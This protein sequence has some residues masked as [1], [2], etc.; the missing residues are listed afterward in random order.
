VN[1]ARS[2]SYVDPF[3]GVDGEGNCLCGPYL[4]HSIVRLGPDTLQPHLSHGYHSDRPIIRFS[5]TH[6]SGT[7]G[8]G[9][10][11]NIGVTPFTGALRTA[12]QPYEKEEESA[13]PG[14]YCVTL[15][16]SN[17]KAELTVTPRV[18]VH[19][20][21]F[22]DVSNANI[23]LDV[24]S[25]IEVGGDIPGNST[26]LSIGG[27][28]E[29]IS[30][31]EVV[32]R[33]DF[34]GGWGHDFPYSVYFYAKL[35]QPIL[36]YQTRN[37]S[38]ELHS[39]SIDGPNCKV[40][41]AFGNQK[42]IGLRVG[43]SYV[44]VANARDSVRKEAR[45]KSFAALR[46]EAADIWEHALQRIR[47]EGGTEQQKT[48]FYTLFTRLIC[49]PSDLGID[50]ENPLWKSGVR[51]F[52]DF[53][54]LW[55]S[56]RNANSL[57]SLF[58]PEL[59]V[60]MLNC[61]LD[62][63][64]HVGW[65]PDAWIMGH[66]AMIQGGS[67][68]DVLLCEAALKGLKGI[69]YHKALRQMRKNNEVESPNTWLYGRHLSDYHSLGYLS[70]NVKKNCVSRHME[71]AYQDWCI[72]RLAE[73]LNDL[74]TAETYYESSRKIWNL[75]RDDIQF[76]AP[77]DPDGKWVE[78]F[79]PASCL[80]DSWND[81]YFYEGTSWQWS[82][83]V[84]HDFSGLIQRH[85]GEEGFI[86]H[87][88]RFFDEGH[89]YSK[90]TM[91]HVPYLYTYAGRPD[92]TAERVRECLDKYFKVAR[93]GLRDNEDMGCQS[94][95]YMCSGIGLYPIMGQDLYLISTPIFKKTEI[96]LGRSGKKLIIEAPAADEGHLYIT[97]ATLNGKPLNRA[98]VKHHE[99]AD[100]A[101]IRLE[102]SQ[103]PG[104]WGMT[105]IPP[106]PLQALN[107]VNSK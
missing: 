104:N 94:A 29:V 60:D 101:V 14:Y 59:E 25:V 17:I 65:L 6:V 31:T 12:L 66:S 51:H 103:K 49:M 61:L 107:S 38:D 18:G 91:L 39:S 64:D 19:R 78:P 86:R 58:D 32:G 15:M 9:R 35:D 50:D 106:S 95:F 84:H 69:D 42:E 1:N 45:A 55:D 11:G 83:S 34:R 62:I 63:A 76:F 57:I 71:Y 53:Y 22:P 16:P 30:D 68:A 40:A 75:W 8:G 33:G 77:K 73:H 20:Y 105:E 36:T 99:I 27:F 85:G 97:S 81:P 79:E 26:G 21:T 46:E 13:A 82:F 41:L 10:Y 89:H 88:D 43:I 52:T 87:L 2:V 48:L 28:L 44:S 102:V 24:G 72:G 67:S 7:G 54:A 70:T 23:L 90:E 96:S 37:Q 80:P 74:S 92:K 98:W 56:V 5:H 100:G 93:N 47:V 3:I 4:P